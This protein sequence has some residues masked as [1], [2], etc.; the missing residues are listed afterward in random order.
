MI[1]V[2]V[3]ILLPIGSFTFVIFL[4]IGSYGCSENQARNNHEFMLGGVTI[5]VF[6]SKIQDGKIGPKISLL[7]G[8][9]IRQFKLPQ[10]QQD[11]YCYT[12]KPMTLKF[13]PS[14]IDSNETLRDDPQNIFEILS[15]LKET[16]L[17]L[18][19]EYLNCIGNAFQVSQDSISS[20]PL[21]I[22]IKPIIYR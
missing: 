15:M 18:F 14:D 8:E 17:S 20:N 5:G 13:Q 2:L 12:S 9:F 19:E 21:P 22:G 6:D 10:D 7:S 11:F 1:E 3:P 16:E 4:T